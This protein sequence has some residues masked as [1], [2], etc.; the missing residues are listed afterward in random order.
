ME[1]VVQARRRA[2]RGVGGKGQPGAGRRTGL[3]HRV[4][5]DRFWR[6]PGLGRACSP[7]LLL[8]LWGSMSP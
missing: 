3:T 7:G 1:L 4:P 8:E 2:G 5:R 6:E